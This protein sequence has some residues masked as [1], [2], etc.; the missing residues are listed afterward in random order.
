MLRL[1]L[2]ALV[3]YV[4]LPDDLTI[5]RNPVVSELVSEPSTVSASETM[6][7]ASSVLSDI[8]GF[9][10]RNP[11][12]CATAHNLLETTKQTIG[13]ELDSLTTGEV[14]QGIRPVDKSTDTNEQ[15]S[16]NKSVPN[17]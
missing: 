16:T 3:V 1:L 12:T 7:A 4:L 10:G 6:E 13:A 14:S 9:C 17:R 8:G 5:N 11:E 15:V 2:A